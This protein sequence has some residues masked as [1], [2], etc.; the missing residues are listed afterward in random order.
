M[1]IQTYSWVGRINM[2][3]PK[4]TCKSN[5]IPQSK[6]SRIFLT[7]FVWLLDRLSRLPDRLQT[8]K[9]VDLRVITD[10]IHIT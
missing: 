4:L 3:L 9:N 2:I 5:A 1:E 10:S 7:C 6:P 8:A